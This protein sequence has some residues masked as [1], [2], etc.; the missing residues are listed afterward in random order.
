MCVCVYTYIYIYIY[1][2]TYTCIYIYI[3]IYIYV[4]GVG[5]SYSVGERQLARVADDQNFHGLRAGA[6][7]ILCYVMLCCCYSI[8]E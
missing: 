6:S 7:I 5:G 2:Y 3:Y 1:I 4:V 8:V